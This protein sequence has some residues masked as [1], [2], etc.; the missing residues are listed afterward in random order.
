MKKI[1]WTLFIGS[2]ALVTLGAAGCGKTE[3]TSTET[4]AQEIIVGT[5]GAGQPFT[6]LDEEG[7]LTG[8][9]VEVLRAIDDKLPEYTF[10]YEQ[11]EFASLFTSLESSKIDLIAN[12]LETNEERQ[13]KYLYATEGYTNYDLY[14]AQND[15]QNYQSLSDLNGKNVP[16]VA[17]GNAPTL[18]EKFNSEEEG[19]IN[20]VYLSNGFE[21]IVRGLQKGS[22]DAT[23]LTKFDIN[24]YNEAYGTSLKASDKPV[25]ESSTYFLYRK[26]DEKEAKLQKAIDQALKSLK[27]EGAL[28]ELSKKWLGDDYTE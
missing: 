11:Y 1:K 21:E 7:E 22:Y 25:N 20:I 28:Q 5:S 17:G 27:E 3:A 13:A 23:L 2:L 26:D 19:D 9:D 8:Y 10:K 12:Q 16:A 24:K 15:D 14:I 6:Y 4:G 18:L